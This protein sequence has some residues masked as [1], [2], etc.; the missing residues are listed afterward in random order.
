MQRGKR[1]TYFCLIGHSSRRALSRFVLSSQLCSGSKRWRAP[2]Q[3]PRPSNFLYVPAQCHARRTKRGPYD[4]C[5]LNVSAGQND[6]LF[7]MTATRSSRTRRRSGRG[8]GGGLAAEAPT[9]VER[10]DG[11]ANEAKGQTAEAHV[12]AQRTSATTRKRLNC[13]CED[14]TARTN[15]ASGMRSF[16]CRCRQLPPL[17][18]H[19]SRHSQPQHRAIFRPHFH[20]LGHMSL[21]Q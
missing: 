5:P 9:P 1:E 10:G 12:A 2:S 13:I 17:R 18:W 19:R 11:L 8:G 7:F 21:L 20:G 4:D 14:A 16:E 6:L 3:P 15:L